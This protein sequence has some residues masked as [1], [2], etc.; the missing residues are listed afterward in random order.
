[1]KKTKKSGKKDNDNICCSFCGKNQGEVQKIIHGFSGNICSECISICHTLMDEESLIFSLDPSLKPKKTKVSADFSLKNISPKEIYEKLNEYVI[2]QDD[3]KKVLSIAVY[4]HYKRILNAKVEKYDDVELSKS[5]VLMVG[6]TGVGKTL[7]AQTLAKIIGVPF[8]IADA[9]SLTEAGYVGEDVETILL[10]LLQAADYDVEK[11]EKGIVYIDEIDKISR[12]S[13]NM[14][15]TRDVSG[16]GVQ[17]ALLKIIEGTIAYVPPQGGRKN[18][19]QEFIPI[20]TSKILFICGGSFAGLDKI[21]AQR[22]SNN[23]IGFN[24]QLKIDMKDLEHETNIYK[25][26]E[27]EDLFKF[28][29]IQEFIGRLPVIVTL[30]KMSVD[31]IYKILK[32][33]K[34]ALSLQYK[35]LFMME[36]VEL[37]FSDEALLAIAKKVY[38][39]SLGARGL[40]AYMEKLLRDTMFEIPNVK[41]EVSKVVIDEDVANLSKKPIYVYKKKVG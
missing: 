27:E 1:M 13:E 6:S 2:G 7:L 32:E 35:K 19:S 33:P 22:K 30:E 24:A 29:L 12:K 39:T 41:T 31:T 28:G 25:D 5:N 40:R 20:D 23:S 21:I 14:S 38:K 10:R 16:E 37:E 9:T 34:N 8:A 26:L 3:A 18:P 36:G 15:I 4:N 17:Q 11:A